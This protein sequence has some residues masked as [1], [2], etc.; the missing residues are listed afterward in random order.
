MVQLY[1]EFMRVSNAAAL[2]RICESQRCYSFVTNLLESAMVQRCREFM[3][4]SNG[5]ALSRI[6]ESQQWYSFVTNL[7]CVN[8]TTEIDNHYLRILGRFCCIEI[9]VILNFTLRQ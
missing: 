7:I 2:S 9:L 5:T 1:H 6:F 4:V 3:R 8:P